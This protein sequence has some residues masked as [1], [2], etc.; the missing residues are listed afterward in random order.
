[1]ISI[2]PVPNLYAIQND[3]VLYDYTTLEEKF[4]LQY[5]VDFVK[6]FVHVSEDLYLKDRVWHSHE[7][8]KNQK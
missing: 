5:E 6:W 8:E 1:M 3:C 4:S 2:L 7:V